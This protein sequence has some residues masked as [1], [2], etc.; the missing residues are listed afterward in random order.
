MSV[1]IMIHTNSFAENHHSFCRSVSTK[2]GFTYPLCLSFA[3]HINKVAASFATSKRLLDDSL[4]QAGIPSPP[5]VICY[6]SSW[7]SY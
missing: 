1:I 2:T 3:V 4:N 5:L 7:H 6:I